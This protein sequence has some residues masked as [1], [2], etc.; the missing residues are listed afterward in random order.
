M[1]DPPAVPVRDVELVVLDMAGTTVHDGGEVP[2]AFRAALAAHGVAVTDEELAGVRGASKH[3]VIRTLVTRHQPDALPS[4]VDEVYDE[5]RAALAERYRAGV[6]AVEGV[7]D[8]FDWLRRRDVRIALNTGFDRS[9]AELLLDALGWRDGVVE[10][11]VCG[12]EVPRGRPAPYL[13]FRAMEAAGATSVHRVVNVGD[14]ELDLRAG[15]NAAVGW[16]VGVLGGAHP[17]ERLE[18][19]PHTHLI[20]SAAALPEL[21]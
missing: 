19:A 8:A 5:F 9:I 21:W 14:T 16:N 7:E 4:L 6:R 12:D 11:V 2:A 3:E 20:D 13:I 1:T 15:W 18:Q 17:R 10:A